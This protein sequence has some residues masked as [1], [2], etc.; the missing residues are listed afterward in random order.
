VE[1]TFDNNHRV[2]AQRGSASGRFTFS[3]ADSGEHRLC[4]TPQ[5]VQSGG[6]WLG[7]SGVHG[8]VKFTLDMAIGETS[9]IE[10][11]DKGKIDDIVQRIIDLNKRMADI[12]REQVFQRVSLFSPWL[13][14]CAG[15]TWLIG[16][17]EREAEFRDQSESTNGR[18]VR[19]TLIQL[20]VLG[21][22]CAWQLSHLRAFFIKQKLT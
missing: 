3:A 21:V 4:V 20:A 19:W 12:R 10:S 18:V 6:G 11:T 7:G 22:T 14:G 17:Q 9:K 1:E 2:V 15:N 8:T 5:N 13:T 16:V